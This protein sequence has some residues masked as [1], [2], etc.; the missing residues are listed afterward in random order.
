MDIHLK[1]RTILHVNRKGSITESLK[2]AG[3]CHLQTEAEVDQFRD[4]R[5]QMASEGAMTHAPVEVKVEVILMGDLHLMVPP[6]AEEV[7][8]PL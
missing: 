3:K 7:D 2:E 6:W 1:T 5:Q 4:H 8:L